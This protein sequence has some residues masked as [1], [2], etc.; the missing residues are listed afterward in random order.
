MQFGRYFPKHFVQLQKQEPFLKQQTICLC[1]SSDFV[2]IFQVPFAREYWLLAGC[3]ASSRGNM[4]AVFKA[5]GHCVLNVGG[6]AESILLQQ[7]KKLKI[8]LKDRKGF[9][10]LGLRSGCVLVPC[11]SFEEWDLFHQYNPPKDSLFEKMQQRFQKIAGFALPLFFGDL[12]FFPLIPR[13][14]PAALYI[15]GGLQ[16]P[17]IES[18]SEVDVDEWHGRYCVWLTEHFDRWKTHAGRGDWELEIVG[19]PW[20]EQSSTCTG[21]PTVSS[22]PT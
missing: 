13:R 3:I 2:S 20:R 11:V 18:P 17:K 14:K 16:L 21:S 15:G 10:R 9:V 22:R 7:P 1:R 8:L 19:D 5:N 6:A 12:F 4:E